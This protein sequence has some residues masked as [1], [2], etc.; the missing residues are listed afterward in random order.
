MK[1]SPFKINYRREPR[2]AFNI[3]KKNM[4]AE[5][6]AKEMKD[7]YEEAKVALVKS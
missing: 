3:R 5:E 2:M 6:F 7:K 1:S 4:K